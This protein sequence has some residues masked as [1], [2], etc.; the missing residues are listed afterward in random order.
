VTTNALSEPALA[1]IE[2]TNFLNLLVV[3]DERAVREVFRDTAQAIGFNAMVADS[4]EHAYRFLEA[5]DIDVVLLDLN[6]PGTGGLDALAH[7]HARKPDVVI[8]VVTGHGTVESAVQAMKSGAYDYVTKPFA[9]EGLRLLLERVSRHL[10]RKTL[11]RLQCERLKSRMGVGTIVG[12]APE[13]EK[14]LRIVAKAA[15]STHPVL[16]VGENGTEKELVARSIHLSGPLRD[17]P[18][19]RVACGSL[20]PTLIESELFGYAKG[21]FSGAIQSRDG[22]LASASGGTLFLDEIG[23]LSVD[24]QAKLLLFMQ[25]KQICRMGSRK[26]V[27]IDVRILASTSRDLEQAVSHGTFRRDLFFQLNLLNA[28]IPPLRERREDIPLLAG[29]FL[30]RG[31]QASGRNRIL[32]DGA[33]KVLL[34]YDWPCNV[35]ELENC[36]ERASA[37]VYASI[38]QAKDVRNAITAGKSGHSEIVPL[39]ELEKQTILDTLEQLKGNK[40]LAATMLGIGKTTLYRKLTDYFPQA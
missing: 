28:N 21:A 15:Q 11:Q 2:G 26:P 37:M 18:F 30:E 20:A 27:P 17:K 6:L 32:S 9:I 12:R 7:I 10:E 36:V 34:A 1:Y 14:L 33:M 29:Y 39:A 40:L 19:V 23:E 22:L 24:V 5:H 35:Q 31:G 38:I 25:E 3:D 4:A 8:V 13:M 16:I